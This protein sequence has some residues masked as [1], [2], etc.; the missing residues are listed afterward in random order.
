MRIHLACLFSIISAAP[1]WAQTLT[2]LPAGIPELSYRVD[3][4]WPELPEGWNLLATPDVAVDAGG[5]VRLTRMMR[6][7]SCSPTF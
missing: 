2:P 4:S 1:G 6:C 7:S 5:V 3:P